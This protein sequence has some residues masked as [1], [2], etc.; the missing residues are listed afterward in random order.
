M[1]SH[2][3]RSDAIHQLGHRAFA[4]ADERDDEKHEE[5]NEA[6]FGDEHRR[7]GENAET[8]NAR[9]ECHDDEGK[10]PG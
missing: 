8:E 4:T 9:D 10:C 3:A 2:G 1:F 7:A 5:K 6:D